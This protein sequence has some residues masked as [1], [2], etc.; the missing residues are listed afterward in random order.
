VSRRSQKDI[1]A[2]KAR[3]IAFVE[4]GVQR[5]KAAIRAGISE[6][7]YYNWLKTD[8]AF[9]EALALAE[10]RREETR[11]RAAVPHFARFREECLGHATFRHQREWLA[12]LKS[13]DRVLILVPPAHGKSMT[14]SVDYPTWRIVRDR[15]VRGI[16]VSKTQDMARKMLYSV[17]KRLADES[18]YKQEARR[19]VVEEWGPFKPASSD[20]GSLVWSAT[21]I[22]VQGIDSSEKDPTLEV[23]GVG[24]QIYGAR[25]DFI[26]LDDIA[27]ISNQGSELEREKLLD[28]I[29]QEVVTRLA[30]GGK[31]IIIGTRV[32][33]HDIYARFLEGGEPWLAGYTRVVQPAILSDKGRPHQRVLCPEL[34]P[35]DELAARRDETSPRTWSLVYQQVSSGMPDSPFSMEALEAAKDLSYSV[36]DVAP[37][38]VP[39]MGVDP[40]FTGTAAIVVLGLDRKT[41][42][43]YVID[44]VAEAGLRTTDRLYDLIVS[45]AAK[46][47]VREC[48]IERNAMQGGIIRDQGFNDRLREVGCRLVEEFTGKYNKYDPDHGVASVA[49][50]FDKEKYRIPW[51][52]TSRTALRS[53]VDELASWRPGVRGIR[54]DRTMALWFAELSARANET[55]TVEV[56]PNYLPEWIKEYAKTPRW[57]SG[58]ARGWG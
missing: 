10:G 8:P 44:V 51:A 46:Y 36:G 18:F 23:L 48:R 5:E 14:F 32:H 57:V 7:S 39:V 9:K 41:G 43:R 2:L 38:L 30:R 11:P 17:K 33:E 27:T 3:I 1:A 15:N 47:R 35:Y 58:I 25:A 12:A 4:A 19:N 6:R 29:S 54:Q 50:L 34:W 52:G 21:K 37:H 20:R 49:A 13:S 42:I 28:W 16:V 45:T 24:N 55:A 40:A 53:F 31:L 22:Y 26:I 56:V